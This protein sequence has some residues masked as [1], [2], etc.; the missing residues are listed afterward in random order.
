MPNMLTLPVALQA[1][2]THLQVS[3]SLDAGL[4]ILPQFPYLACHRYHRLLQTPKAHRCHRYNG[5]QRC[6][7]PVDNGV[8]LGLLGLDDGQPIGKS[9][10]VL[11]PLATQSCPP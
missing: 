2:N 7:A 10:H 11:R 8:P 1:S 5:F 3:D 6:Q 9:G 4:L